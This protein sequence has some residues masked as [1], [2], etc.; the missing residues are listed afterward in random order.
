MANI[1]KQVVT[2]EQGGIV[3]QRIIVQYFDDVTNDDKQTITNYDNLTTEEKATFDAF[4]T[5]SKSKMI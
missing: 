5:L 1:L 4:I 2:Q 3:P